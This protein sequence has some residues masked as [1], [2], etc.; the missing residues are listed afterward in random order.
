MKTLKAKHVVAEKSKDKILKQV[1]EHT[2][3]GWNNNPSGE[4][5]PYYQRRF[6]ITIEHNV[7]V[8]R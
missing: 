1:M 5:L 7:A 6:E 2:R 3:N 4:I 8:G